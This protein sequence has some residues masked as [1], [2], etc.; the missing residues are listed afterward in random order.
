MTM[1]EQG[2]KFTQLPHYALEIVIGM[3]GR[4][5]LYTDGLNMGSKK[6]RR[7]AMIMSDINIRRFITYV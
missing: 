7:G 1:Q 3:R 6:Y 5:G 4:I 2:F